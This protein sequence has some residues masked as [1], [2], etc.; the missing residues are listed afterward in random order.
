MAVKETVWG[1]SEMPRITPV[2]CTGKKP[3]GTT[4]KSRIV[5]AVAKFEVAVDVLNHHD[6]VINDEAGR[7]SQGH[8]REIVQAVDEQIHHTESSDQRKGHCDAGNNGRRKIPE[9]QEDDHDDE[10]NGE[11]H[12]ELNVVDRGANGL[13]SIGQD[14]EFH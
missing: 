12:F 2:S 4:I 11:H 3:L 13:G 6:N 1:A 7:D 10:A 8:E 5:R 9:K 14:G